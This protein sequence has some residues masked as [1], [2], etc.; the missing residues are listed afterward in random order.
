M[1][2]LLPPG[3]IRRGFFQVQTC[4]DGACQLFLP[5]GRNQKA[6]SSNASRPPGPPAR[7]RHPTSGFQAHIRPAT[8]DQFQPS[9]PVHTGGTDAIQPGEGLPGF[10]GEGRERR[11]H[12]IPVSPLPPCLI[13]SVLL[14]TV[15]RQ[16][17]AQTQQPQQ[18]QQMPESVET[19]QDAETEEKV[20]TR[21]CTKTENTAGKTSFA[22]AK[23]TSPISTSPPPPT[24]PYQDPGSK[25]HQWL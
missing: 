14:N 19:S 12:I 15:L 22:Q 2:N 20:E 5:L 16:Q 21:Q 1:P 10:P 11:H 23:L 18:P 8:T 9:T 17:A 24:P 6:Y 13:L 7:Q 25:K 4:R 3:G